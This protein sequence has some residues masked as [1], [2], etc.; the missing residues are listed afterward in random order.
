MTAARPWADDNRPQRTSHVASQRTNGSLVLLDLESG[1]YYTLEGSGPEV[2]G[3]CDGRHPLQSIVATVSGAH[4][5]DPEVV[6]ADVLELLDHLTAE[7]LL[8]VAE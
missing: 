5:V 1:R 4:D 7:G 3:L 2:W 6:R 8:D